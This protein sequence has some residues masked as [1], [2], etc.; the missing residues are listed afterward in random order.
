IETIKAWIRTCELSHI[1]CNAQETTMSLY[2][3]DVVAECI[4]FMPT[5]RTNYVALS[6]VWGNVECTKLNRENLNALQAAGSLSSESDIAIIPHTI[7]DAMR[8]TAELD[9]R[10]LW[11]D[12]LCL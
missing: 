10:Y 4:K 5:A 2:L 1:S 3:V 11:V 7:R 6:Y 8:L 9:I 12:S